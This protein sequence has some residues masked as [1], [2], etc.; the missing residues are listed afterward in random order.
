MD[1]ILMRG[2]YRGYRGWGSENVG[3]CRK[4]K[5]F[6]EASDRAIKAIN[7]IKEAKEKEEK[8]NDKEA[9]I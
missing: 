5:I 1:M 7:T 6:S 8:A 4:E 9:E 3:R 2:T